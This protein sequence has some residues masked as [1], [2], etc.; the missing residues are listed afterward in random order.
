[1][2]ARGGIVAKEKPFVVIVYFVA[3]AFAIASV[4]YLTLGPAQLPS[5]LPGHLARPG[6]HPPV[7]HMRALV[8]A[9]VA[10][11]LACVAWSDSTYGKRWRRHRRD[12][13]RAHRS[14]ARAGVPRA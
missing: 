5:F 1:M 6:H 2:R 7:Y 13:H 8:C 14:A 11:V 10:L 4:L 9:L 3:C 12:A